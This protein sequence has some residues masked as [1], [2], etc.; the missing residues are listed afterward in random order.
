MAQ[1]IP[2]AAS[3]TGDV[4]P[5]DQPLAGQSL[6]SSLTLNQGVNAISAENQSFERYGLGLSASGGEQTNFLGTQT[7]QQNAAYAQ[8]TANGGLILRSSRTLYY[9]LYQPQYTWYPQFSEVN[10]FG[11]TAYQTIDH[12]LSER[13]GVNWNTTAARYLSLNQYLPQTL[14][15]GGVG[16][17]VPTLGTQLLENSWIISG[18]SGT[19]SA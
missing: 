14:G 5:T 7:N 15:I 6:G 13:A 1:A 19:R 3:P 17:V 10:N 11:Q 8:F 2:A 18:L 12:V 4:S 16:V 9:L